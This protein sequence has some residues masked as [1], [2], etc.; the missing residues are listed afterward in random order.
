[1][2]A[3]RVRARRG[4]TSRN[5][6]AIGL[7]PM[8]GEA[9]KHDDEAIVGDLTRDD[10]K[11]A[12]A[13]LRGKAA[14]VRRQANAYPGN[15]DGPP[16]TPDAQEGLVRKADKLDHVAEKVAARAEISPQLSH[17]LNV[18][19]FQD[20]FGYTGERLL[21]LSSYVLA[22]KA[23][24]EEQVVPF[25]KTVSV[26]AVDFTLSDERQRRIETLPF[27]VGA[28]VCG[29]LTATLG[30]LILLVAVACFIA[31]GVLTWRHN[32][33]QA[34]RIERSDVTVS[35]EVRVEATYWNT[36]PENKTVYPPDLGN[37]VRKIE[38]T[39]DVGFKRPE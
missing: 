24:H 15:T 6:A 33:P 10:F 29:V 18:E 17:D 22:D 30:Q 3:T 5:G 16:L 25:A 2:P 13:A 38:Y 9:M 20:V 27:V 31:A 21:Q 39:S 23:G 1:L 28:A 36:F 12:A 11:T 26:P 4:Q 34:L 35:G 7:R 14:K 19:T 8:E 32:A 37:V